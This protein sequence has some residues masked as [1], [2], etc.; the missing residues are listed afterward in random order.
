MFSLPDLRVLEV[1]AVVI[2]EGSM[3]AAGLRLGITQSAVSQAMKRAEA[4]IGASLVRRDRRPLGPTEAGQALLTHMREIT[5]RVG[6]AVEKMRAAAARPEREDLRLGMIDTFAS[7]VGPL[8]VRS[9]MAGSIALRVSAYSGLVPAHAEALMRNEIDAAVTSDPMEGV[10]EVTRLPLLREPFLLVAP[11]AWADTLRDRPL[12]DLLLEHRLIR[13]TARS[14]M[15]TQIER[16]LRRLRIEHPQTMSFD[17]SDSLLS[18]VA[19]GIGVAITTPL[20]ILQAAVHR[21]A[22][23]VMPLPATGLS[24]TIAL[25]TK[26]GGL[27]TLAAR[28]ADDTCVLLRNWTLPQIAAQIPWM[29]RSVGSIVLDPL[30]HEDAACRCVAGGSTR[31]LDEQYNPN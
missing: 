2:E 18:M 17:T 11:I 6:R 26:Q 29:A 10:D 21:P 22:L 8:L 1:A 15:G 4:H 25:V 7:T 27:G 30:A 13:Y 12:D 28:I 3:S 16:H 24:R 20:C 9:L 14:H 31:T 5:L 23:E 19:N